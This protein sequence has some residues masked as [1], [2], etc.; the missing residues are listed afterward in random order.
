MIARQL[1]LGANLHG[2]GGHEGAWRWPSADPNA[3]INI[4]HYIAG[5]QIAE[6]GLFDVLFV[7]DSPAVQPDLAVQPPTTGF[8]P[9]VLLSAIATATSAIGLIATASTTYNDPYNLAR[10]LLSLDVISDGRAAWNAVTTYNPAATANFGGYELDREA[11]YRRAEEFVE[12]VR[13][14]WQSW[15]DGAIVADK[16]SGRYLDTARLRP[17]ERPGE[18]FS[19]RGPLTLPGSRQGYPVILQAG[20]SDAGQRLAAKSADVVFSAAVEL[21]LALR[22]AEKVRA[23]ARRLGREQVPLIM[24]GL[25]T[26]IGGTERE[27][28]QRRQALDALI[29][30]ETALRSLAAKLGVSAEAL[31]L[32]EPVPATLLPALDD[33][34][35]PHGFFQTIA[36]LV[37][38]RRTVREI[39]SAAQGRGNGH[40]VICGTPEQIAASIAEWFEAG[41]ADGFNIMPDVQADGLPAFVDMVVPL[42]QRRGIFRTAYAG[43]TLREHL[44]IGRPAARSAAA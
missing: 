9:T 27:A 26:I 31:A 19:V 14:L 33:V 5:A 18:H 15:E 4:K 10:R 8:E 16:A 11:R 41:A 35:V 44:G 13:A 39:A 7:G 22:E 12:L 24:P 3:F 6:S 40:R 30:G 1:H 20:G 29:D 34:K 2:P 23:A 28:I 21:P 25:V 37:R 42:L 36:H 38:E 32:D 43:S 17:V